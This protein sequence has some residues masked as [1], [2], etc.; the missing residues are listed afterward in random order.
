MTIL[1]YFDLMND[2][3]DKGIEQQKEKLFFLVVN[4]VIFYILE[5]LEF[6]FLGF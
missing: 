1:D 5:F 2:P 4:L 6:C 3:F